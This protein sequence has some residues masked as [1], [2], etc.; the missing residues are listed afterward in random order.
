[1]V[2]SSS[3]PWFGELRIC[4]VNSTYRENSITSKSSLLLY[5]VCMY[6]RRRCP[7]ENSLPLKKLINRIKNI[8]DISNVLP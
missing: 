3:T 5:G 1:M 6:F 4:W 8:K 7:K 2:H